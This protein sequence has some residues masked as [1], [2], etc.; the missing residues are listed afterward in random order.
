MQNAN[1]LGQFIP[2]HYHYNMLQDKVR[3]EGF[4]RAIDL[5]V[6]PDDVVIE[7]GG[8]TGVLSFYAAQKAKKVYCVEYNGELVEE[9]RRFLSLNPNGDR[10]EVVHGDAS[11]FV[12]PEKIHVVVCE[13]LHVAHLREKQ[14]NVIQAFKENYGKKYDGHIPM[15]IPGA[16]IHAVQLIQQDFLFFGYN[17]PCI[18]FQDPYSEQVRTTQLSTPAVYYQVMYDLPYQTDIEWK[19]KIQVA[20]DGKLNALRFITKNVLSVAQEGSVD[21]HNQY[22]VLPLEEEMDLTAGQVVQV[23]FEYESGAA[24]QSVKPTLTIV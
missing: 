7:L 14:L 18:L 15:F 12:P 20:A 16:T 2:L 5:T 10:V 24:I 23:E 8:G 22:L 3:M 19:G 4:K 11:K 21:W 13:M 9:A 6:Q 17:A 1:E